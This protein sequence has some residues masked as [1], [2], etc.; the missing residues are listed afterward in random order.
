MRRLQLILVLATV[1]AASF[2]LVTA[3]AS[4][5]HHGSSHRHRGRCPGHTAGCAR[6]PGIT[7]RWKS[8]IPGTFP[9][10]AN[11]FAGQ[12]LYVYPGGNPADHRHI[13]GTQDSLPG[14]LFADGE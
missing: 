10:T 2:A 4:A 13:E 11:P 7:V 6:H 1:L 14:S 9:L 3:V 5:R 8:A 12:R